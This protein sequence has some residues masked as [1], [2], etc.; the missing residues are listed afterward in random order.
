[1]ESSKKICNAE[2]THTF[3][4]L[5]W[6]IFIPLSNTCKGFDSTHYLDKN[7]SKVSS[8]RSRNISKCSV[9]DLEGSKLALPKGFKGLGRRYYEQLG[10]EA[11]KILQVDPAVGITE[12]KGSVRAR[13]IQL[14]LE[15]KSRG[16]KENNIVVIFSKSHANQTIAVLASLFL[17]AIVA[18]LDPEFSNHECLELLKKLK[19][20]MCF[21]DTRPMNQVQTVLGQLKLNA[22]LIHFGVENDGIP[23]QTL[24]IHKEDE[25][26]QPVSIEN[27]KSSVA[28]ILPTQGTTSTPKLVCLSHQNIYVQTN[29]LLDIFNYPERIVSSFPLSWILQTV[30][31]CASFEAGVVRILPPGSLTERNACKM[32][33]DFEIGHAIFSTEYAKNLINNA[34]I[35]VRWPGL[36]LARRWCLDGFQKEEVAVAEEDADR[37]IVTTA[38]SKR[39]VADPVVIMGE[40]VDLFVLLNGLGAEET[41]VYLQKSTKGEAGYCHYSTTSY[42]QQDSQRSPGTVLFTHPFTGPY[43]PGASTPEQPRSFPGA[44]TYVIRRRGRLVSRKAGADWPS[45]YNLSC[46]KCVLLSAINT[47]YEIQHLKK[48]LPHVKFLQCYC[49]TETGCVALTTVETYNSSLDRPNSVGR[50]SYNSKI[51]ILD[52][53]TKE[54]LGQDNYGELYF[55]GEGVMLG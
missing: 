35:K 7:M 15:M 28:F 53:D 26:F 12:T 22:P 38:L 3:S 8:L 37:E 31:A 51:K 20:K 23:F 47:Q 25:S 34:G 36:G 1:M 5:T 4:G 39:A 14:A 29:T 42:N 10:L 44:S 52:L 32:I 55:S 49:L 24:F 48:L 16:I 17:G 40:D 41:N 46:L 43:N 18:P 6:D 50:L 9:P 13:S 2:R 21:C 19:P 33:H 54:S 11:N 27:P 30:L 45:D